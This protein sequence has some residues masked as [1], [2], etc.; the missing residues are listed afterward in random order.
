MIRVGSVAPGVAPAQDVV[1]WRPPL[2]P[3][4]RGAVTGIRGGVVSRV[5]ESRT[6]PTV[7]A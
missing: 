7:K 3:V 4:P 5:V 6:T 1:A 2:V